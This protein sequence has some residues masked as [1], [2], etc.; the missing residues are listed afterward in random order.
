MKRV[1][2]ADGTTIAVQSSGSGPPLVLVVGA[3]SDRSSTASLAAALASDY[4]V[5]E[6]DRRGR[7][8]STDTPPYAVAREVEDLAAVVATTDEEPFAFGHSSGGCLVLEATSAGVPLRRA[9]VYEPPYNPEATDALADELAAEIAAGQ[10]TEV[11]ER[12]L[13]FTGAPP[14][15]VAQ[16]KTGPAWPRLMSFAATLPYEVRLA[17]DGSP[18]VQRLVHVAVPVLALAGGASAAWALAGA[19]AIATAVPAGESLV[20]AGQ[21][22][23]VADDVLVPVLREF[24]R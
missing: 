8:D 11:V 3:F 23:G 13:A 10:R 21:G 16:M 5:I 24:F 15:V 7:G 14:D 6:Y 12:F 2:S 22:H 19:P 18:P 1:E 17:N 20:L 4:T 9:A